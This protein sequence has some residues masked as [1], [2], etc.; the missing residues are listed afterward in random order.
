MISF[1]FVLLLKT[2][3]C[4]CKFL[5]IKFIQIQ[6]QEEPSIPTTLAQIFS[7]IRVLSLQLQDLPFLRKK[8][9]ITMQIVPTTTGKDLAECQIMKAKMTWKFSD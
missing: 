4:G 1:W 8:K 5:K 9:C 7:Q 2:A 3:P 6:N